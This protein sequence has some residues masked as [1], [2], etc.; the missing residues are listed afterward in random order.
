M[1]W[2]NLLPFHSFCRLFSSFQCVALPSGTCK[3]S[4]EGSGRKERKRASLA[5]GG[6]TFG[7]GGG[8]GGGGGCREQVG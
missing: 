8:G 7:E 4:W 2:L 1:F 5:L 6:N 3:I